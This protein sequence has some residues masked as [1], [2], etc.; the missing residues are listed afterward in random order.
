MP[1]QPIK[2]KF[3]SIQEQPNTALP[4]VGY[5]PSGYDPL[6]PETNKNPPKV[7]VYKH[8]QKEKRMQLVVTPTGSSNVDFVGTN[9]LGEG[10]APQICKYALGV[11]DKDTG[12]LKIVPIAANK[13]FRLEPKIRNMD[14]VDKELGAHEEDLP[15]EERWAKRR[16]LTEQYETARSMKQAKKS[17]NLRAIEATPQEGEQTEMKV[18]APNMEAL[19]STSADTARNIPP[20][21]LSASTPRE[22]YPLDKIIIQGEWGFLED[23]YNHLLSSDEVLSKDYP[24]FV[25]NRIHKLLEIEDEAEKKRVACIFS[26]ITHLIKFKDQHSMEGYVSA[27]AHRFPNILQQ[28]FKSMFANPGERNLELQKINLLTGYVLVLTLHADEFQT[29][30]EDIA[31]DL[32]QSSIKLR[33]HLENLGCKFRRDKNVLKAGLSVPLKF[34][35]VVQ[36]RR[37]PPKGGR[38]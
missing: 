21:N 34:P 28:K 11:L 2:V 36:R 5:F 31:Q 3:H 19:E 38:R 37:G 16:K 20:Y 25:R 8:K 18:A 22:A 32:R 12:V 23:I 33:P 14:S 13:I 26:Y 15:Q 29:D 1:Q 30:P 24:R 4:L 10:Q 6:N 27:K 17:D 35:D 7:R 9:Y